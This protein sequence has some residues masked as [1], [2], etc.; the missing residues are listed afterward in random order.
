[1]SELPGG[2]KAGQCLR[3]W[4][5]DERCLPL[6][7]HP[8]LDGSCD[9]LGLGHIKQVGVQL[10]AEAHGCG[11]RGLVTSGGPVLQ[12][13]LRVS[14]HIFIPVFHKAQGGSSHMLTP[15]MFPRV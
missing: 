11:A 13:A 8:Y 1:M 10:A 6:H 12:E 7:P 9:G 4:G 5:G 2:K 15:C 14:S 3:G